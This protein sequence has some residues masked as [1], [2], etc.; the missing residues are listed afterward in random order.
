MTSRPAPRPHRK[1]PRAPRTIA[2][3]PTG[4]EGLDQLTGGGLP[5][6]RP[7]LVSG[8][9]GC[10]KTLLGME[11]LVRGA[12]RFDEPGVFVAFEETADELAKNV[13]S[14]GFD[15]DGLVAQKLL[16]VDYVHVD[17]H[18]IEET[19]EYNLDGL[20]VRLGA[21]LDAVGAKRIVLD[22]LEVLFGGFT[23]ALTLRGEIRR[24]FRWLKERGVTAVITAERLEGTLTR[25]GLEEYVSD[26][27]ILLDHR[28]IDQVSTR[29]LRIVKYRGSAHGTNEYPFLIAD[30]GLSVL[31]VTALGL[32]YPVSTERVST[33]I[34]R[35]DEM[36]GGKGYFR[37]SSVLVS[38]TAGTG[39]SS[40]AAS[41]V[42][43]ACRRGE[44][45]VYFALEESPAQVVRNMRSIGLG[46]DAWVDKGLLRFQAARP[47]LFGLEMHLISMHKTIDDIAPRA[48]VLDPI[49]SLLTAGS[50]HDVKAMLVRLFDHLKLR[51]VTA[52][53]TSLTQ[54][55]SD[56]DSVVG[57]SSLIDT[58]LQLRDLETGGERNRG[59]YVVKSRGMSHS[60]QVREF[61]ISDRGIELVD[62][63][64]GP[65]GVL[66]GSARVSQEAADRA[67][68]AAREHEAAGRKRSLAR[69]KTAF[70]AQLQAMRAEF[71]A[72]E[73]ELTNM[74]HEAEAQE[75]RLGAERAEMHRARE[76]G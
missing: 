13:A 66:T 34:A 26:C 23:D 33:G 7:T 39:K 44:S 68:A 36:L 50:A 64:A 59:L 45:C 62:V 2:K 14:L 38:G 16:A 67:A 25:Y 56:E 53:L 22:T 40:I 30:D 76:G 4:I 28:T 18:E 57:I 61:L 63:Y 29:R 10:G 19:G 48:V 71:A 72:E 51:G 55:P 12:T 74:I 6:G 11:F 24:L 54:A 52:L 73:E 60:N 47:T 21:A 35:L 31:P 27:V 70:E 8:G 32:D 41:F 58:W 46:L 42:D 1:T 43:A 3:A 17:P 15:L 20:F 9:P 49:S 37:A 5:A 65:G 75:L 69:R